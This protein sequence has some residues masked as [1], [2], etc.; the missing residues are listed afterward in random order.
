MALW[1]SLT[2]LVQRDAQHLEHQTIPNEHCDPPLADASSVAAGE[3]Y[4][5][6]WATQIFLRR[7]RQWFKSW[8]PVVQASTRFRFGDLPDPVEVVQVA[9]PDYL[10]DVDPEHL[11]RV[12]QIDCPLTP[13]LPFNG[14]TVQL[15]VGLLAMQ[16]SDT[17][18]R[19]L[20]VVGSFASLLAVPQFSTALSIASVVSKGV[21]QLL[22]A[23]EKQL[24]VGYQRTFES[25]GG[26]GA[27]DLRP[28]Y[29]A[30]INAPAGTYPASQLWVAEGSL[31]YGMDRG[32]ATE[33]TGVDYLLLRVATRRYRDDWEALSTISQPFSKAIAAL[34][35]VDASGEAN[36]AAA[37]VFIRLAATASLTSPDLAA[38]DRA[39]VARAMRKRYTEYRSALFGD[40]ELKN[41]PAPGLADVAVTARQMDA[42]PVTVDELFAV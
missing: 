21:D 14:G 25:A 30:I 32:Q 17:M 41:P 42:C 26:G 40:R 5:Q 2:Q 29:I 11:D 22:G 24:V 31:L 16:A 23:E 18:R 4:F 6:I 15:E 1:E 3:G 34:T 12:V 33:L 37:E 10:R 9:G 39:Q 28:L 38:R 36:V 8:Y 7:D 13:L 20:E 27:A 19:F 35:Q